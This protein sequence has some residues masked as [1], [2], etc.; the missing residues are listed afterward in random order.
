MRIGES[1]RTY[2]ALRGER[3]VCG[4]QRGG[5]AH[6]GGEQAYVMCRG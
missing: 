4:E 2:V 3:V 5:Q 6:A 1:S